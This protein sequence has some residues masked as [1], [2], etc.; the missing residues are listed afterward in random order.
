[1]KILYDYQIFS[2]QKV[3]GVSR[4]FFE[5][6]KELSKNCEISLPLFA[7]QNLYLTKNKEFISAKFLYDL[8]F[9]GSFQLID[10]PIS[11]INRKITIDR[12]IKS[13]FDVFHPTWYNSYF[14]NFCKRP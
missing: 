12:L 1:M 14:Y 2:A 11:I 3:G 7:T 8:K 9:K 4:Y 6:I 5:I 13:D 10:R